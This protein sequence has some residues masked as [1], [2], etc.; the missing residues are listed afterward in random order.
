MEKTKLLENPRFDKKTSGTGSSNP[1][2]FSPSVFVLGR[3][4]LEIRARFAMKHDPESGC[5]RRSMA[6]CGKT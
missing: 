3:E 6:E 1:F 5:G 2:R 4:S